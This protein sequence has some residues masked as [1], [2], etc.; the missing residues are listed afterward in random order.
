VNNG[1]SNGGA[2]IANEERLGNGI[3]V[4]PARQVAIELQSQ[5]G[6]SDEFFLEE[7]LPVTL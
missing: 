6:F 5:I 3:V 1:R 4:L 7:C 2:V